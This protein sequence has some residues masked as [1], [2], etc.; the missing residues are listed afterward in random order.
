MAEK[1]QELREAEGRALSL[2]YALEFVPVFK[3][4]IIE[5]PEIRISLAEDSIL[6]SSQ[7]SLARAAFDY[8]VVANIE[9]DFAPSNQ[10]TETFY[11]ASVPELF[12]PIGS[13]RMKR[14]TS[15]PANSL[16]QDLDL[17]GSFFSFFFF[18]FCFL[19]IC[20]FVSSFSSQFLIVSLVLGESSLKKEIPKEIVLSHDIPHRT[21]TTN[22]FIPVVC[23][24]CGQFIWGI[25]KEAIGCHDCEQFWHLKCEQFI[26]NDCGLNRNLLVGTITKQGSFDP[27][28]CLF[29][30]FL[31]TESYFGAETQHGPSSPTKKKAP[32]S[33]TKTLKALTQ[34]VNQ[35]QGKHAER[36][37]IFN[38]Y[39]F[40][41]FF[42]FKKNPI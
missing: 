39:K 31:L 30:L 6:T 4:P 11:S 1:Q 34:L 26:A 18:F 29:P 10:S 12:V 3:D 38:E 16:D 33:A 9:P 7:L 42:V 40:V 37:H 22:L 24:Y 27:T 13:E 14:S 5:N 28:F 23:S 19:L 36:G 32:F 25:Y 17:D 15:L 20:W 41:G 8:S 2:H 21:H 35:S